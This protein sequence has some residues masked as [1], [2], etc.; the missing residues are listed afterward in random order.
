MCPRCESNDIT[1]NGTAG[2]FCCSCGHFF[3]EP[4]YPSEDSEEDNLNNAEKF[5]LE[6]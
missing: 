2:W 3:D 6:V 5:I 4:W 1:T